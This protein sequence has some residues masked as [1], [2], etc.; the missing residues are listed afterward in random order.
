MASWILH[1]IIK[2]RNTS[3]TNMLNAANFC[4][5]YKEK[6][7]VFVSLVSFGVNFGFY[8]FTSI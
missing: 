2:K 3:V 4:V 6:F 7:V 8:I 5:E 1:F